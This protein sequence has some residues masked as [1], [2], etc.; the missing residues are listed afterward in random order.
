MIRLFLVFMLC[1]ISILMK[2]FRYFLY[3][4]KAGELPTRTN[5]TPNQLIDKASVI[6][7]QYRFCMSFILTDF[8][9]NLLS[10]IFLDSVMSYVK[11][12][13]SITIIFFIMEK[14]AK[15]FSR[16]LSSGDPPMDDIDIVNF[17]LNIKYL[18]IIFLFILTGGSLALITNYILYYG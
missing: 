18:T 4:L 11:C 14:Y 5:P 16:Y 1:I 10:R 8:L 9:T 3:M 6:R 17:L 2:T 15:W 13:L 7:N 12:V